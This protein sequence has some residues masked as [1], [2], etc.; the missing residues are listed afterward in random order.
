VEINYYQQFICYDAFLLVSAEF[1]SFTC[2]RVWLYIHFDYIVTLPVAV[3]FNLEVATP[4]GV[5]N[6]FWMG[7]K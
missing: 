3:V 6:H 2:I 7:C 4:K 1:L 5:V